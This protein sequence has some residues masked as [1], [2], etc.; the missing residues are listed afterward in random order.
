VLPSITVEE[1]H[2]DPYDETQI[3]L[4]GIVNAR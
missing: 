3:D 2:F 4:S 1:S